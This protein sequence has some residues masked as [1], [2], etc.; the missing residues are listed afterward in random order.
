[1]ARSAVPVLLNTTVWTPVLVLANA[2]VAGV[3]VTT[4]ALVGLGVAGVVADVAGVDPPP[5]ATSTKASETMTAA[6]CQTRIRRNISRLLRPG[7][8][9]SGIIGNPA[10]AR[11]SHARR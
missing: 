3:R 11:V 4:G 5:Q 2:R 6:S 7:S 1:M 8:Q 9:R 10:T